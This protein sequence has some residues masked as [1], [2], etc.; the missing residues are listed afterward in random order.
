MEEKLQN[1]FIFKLPDG[2]FQK[3]LA[4]SILKFYQNSKPSEQQ[5]ILGK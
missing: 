4:N 1:N 5:N 3:K 2:I